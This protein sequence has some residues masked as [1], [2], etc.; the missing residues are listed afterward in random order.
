[1]STQ[2]YRPHGKDHIGRVNLQHCGKPIARVGLLLG[3]SEGLEILREH[4]GEEEGVGKGEGCKQR[5][6]AVSNQYVEG[7]RQ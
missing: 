3:S 2:R 6:M 1:V 4:I 7:E 5:W